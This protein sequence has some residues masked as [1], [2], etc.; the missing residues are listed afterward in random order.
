[1]GFRF[2]IPMIASGYKPN[3]FDKNGPRKGH[4]REPSEG[5]RG[6]GP[7]RDTDTEAYD[8]SSPSASPHNVPVMLAITIANA[9]TSI[10]VSNDDN[11]VITTT[12]PISPR[13]ECHRIRQRTMRLVASP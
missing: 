11:L 6:V 12:T 4:P 9:A 7:L 2:P 3:E 1:V 5:L 13:G 8:W 10:S